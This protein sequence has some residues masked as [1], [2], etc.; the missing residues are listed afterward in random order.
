MAKKKK[1]KSKKETPRRRRVELLRPGRYFTPDG[2]FEATADKI[3][4]IAANAA[5]WQPPMMADPVPSLEATLGP[6]HN[7][8]G[9]KSPRLGSVE[10]VVVDDG[11]LVGDLVPTA[12]LEEAVKA[13]HYPYL[14][15]EVKKS[16]ARGWYLNHVSLLGTEPPAMQP[17]HRLAENVAEGDDEPSAGIILTAEG[18]YW[19]L[20]EGDGEPAPMTI[21]EQRA[22]AERDEKMYDVWSA[23]RTALDNIRD[24][25]LDDDEKT[26]KLDALITEFQNELKPLIALTEGGTEKMGDKKKEPVAKAEPGAALLEPGAAELTAKLTEEDQGR[27]TRLEEENATLRRKSNL[28]EAAVLISRKVPA[29]VQPN[30]AEIYVRLAEADGTVKL[31]EGKEKTPLVA[32]RELLESLPDLVRLGEDAADAGGAETTAEGVTALT[33]ADRRIADELGVSHEDYAKAK[34]EKFDEIGALPAPVPTAGV[35]APAVTEP[36]TEV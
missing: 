8:T 24:S 10:D 28:A 25:D 21:A 1:G 32:Y 23:F 17:Q 12:P 19:N 29:A 16:P 31:A 2:I 13:G 15:I 9:F 33:D 11:L 22:D 4:E 20:A 35:A 26:T 3:N 5:G 14:S 34:A 30:A 27:L 7:E 36:K 18:E 6:H